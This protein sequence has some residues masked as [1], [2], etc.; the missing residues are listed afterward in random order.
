MS[1]YSA[2]FV[3]PMYNE[4]EAI[5]DTVEEIRIIAKT[6]TSDYEI[7]IADDASTD[8]SAEIVDRLA[9]ED[10]HI[11]VVHLLSNTKFGGALIAGLNQATKDIVIYTDSDLPVSFLDIKK[12]LLLLEDA[13]IVTAASIV[14]KG[15]NI[16]RK[17]IS[18]VYNFLIQTLFKANIKDINSGYKIYKRNVLK[19]M[20]L[21]S[22]SP[23]IDVEIF[24][25]AK[26]SGA[27]IKEFPIYFRPRRQGA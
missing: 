15:E 19:G 7:I 27:K 9:R 4:R 24:L 20:N 11:K 2:S 23:F 13:D 25:K 21:K 10:S 26:Q 5:E 18:K 8:G 3:L 22:A 6:L 16:K 12:S 17:I 14:K 1:S